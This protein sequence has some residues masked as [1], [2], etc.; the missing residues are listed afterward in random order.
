MTPY[1]FDITHRSNGSYV[2][3]CGGLSASSDRGLAR[4]LVEDD[5]PDGPID[6]GPVGKTHWTTPSL[7]LFAAGTL[8]EGDR[9]FE[10]GIYTVHPKAENQTM[11]PT[12]QHAVSRLR[13]ARQATSG[14]GGATPLPADKEKPLAPLPDALGETT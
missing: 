5:A 4:L 7:H 14:G 11:H 8:S 2:V 3:R 9:G 10:R 13:A 6:A 1:R 12:L